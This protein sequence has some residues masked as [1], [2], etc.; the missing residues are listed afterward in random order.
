MRKL[1][2]LA[3]ILLTLGLILG[4]TGCDPNPNPEIDWTS[5]SGSNAAFYIDNAT[6][7]RLVAF[8]GSLHPNNLLGGIEPKATYHGIK[9]N[10]SLFNKTEGFPVIFITEDQYTENKNRLNTLANIPFSREYVTYNHEQ[11]NPQ[12]Y[13]ISGQVGG[14]HTLRVINDTGL[15]VALKINGHMGATIGYA[16]RQMMQTDFRMNPGDF[17]IFPV[18]QYYNHARNV[19]AKSYPKNLAGGRF[20][21]SFN[22]PTTGPDLITNWDLNAAFETIEDALTL[23]ACWVMFYNESPTSAVSVE[24]GNIPLQDTFGDV[25]FRPGT[26][27]ILP[28]DMPGIGVGS[29]EPSR[30]ISNLF[31]RA[32]SQFTQ[33]KDEDGKTTF[34]LKTDHQYTVTVTGNT[35]VGFNA[36]INIKDGEGGTPV[37][38]RALYDE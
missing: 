24:V 18:F 22:F 36:V 16:S 28:I 25:L 21:E 13:E 14:R 4:F 32:G 15:D 31:V 26:H 7:F 20:F 8:K 1:F 37:N 3:I 35:M 5:Y 10:L 17:L 23:G 9:K 33:V 11:D 29:F 27:R 6:D 19:V 38:V 30:T 2:K 12:S 34:T